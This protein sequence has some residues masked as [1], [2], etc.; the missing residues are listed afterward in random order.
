MLSDKKKQGDDLQLVLL[1][2]LG[3]YVF[4]KESVAKWRNRS[5]I[6]ESVWVPVPFNR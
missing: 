6:P 1:S 5:G 3:Q 4:V 2:R